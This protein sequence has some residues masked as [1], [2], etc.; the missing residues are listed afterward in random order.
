MINKVGSN[1]TCYKQLKLKIFAVQVLTLASTHL[2]YS[3]IGKNS[4]H[5]SQLNNLFP[6]TT[7]AQ[8]IF[9]MMP[10]IM[11]VRAK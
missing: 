9:A 8:N 3:F 6:A 4:N 5:F 7:V 11:I 10:S 2:E 1:N